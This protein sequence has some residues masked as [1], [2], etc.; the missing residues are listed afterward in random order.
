MTE[1]CPDCGGS[2]QR[3]TAR[4]ARGSELERHERSGTPCGECAGT[5]RR[6]TA[7][8]CFG[9]GA[10]IPERDAYC[11]ECVAVQHEAHKREMR[12]FDEFHRWADACAKAS[13][14]YR[15]P[16]TERTDDA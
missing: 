11:D 13:P 7:A 2:G 15:K 6:S 3:A 1:T 5:G 9:C 10:A 16:T 12:A 8:T 14:S 4:T